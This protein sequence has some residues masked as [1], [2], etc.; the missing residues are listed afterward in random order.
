M[1][2]IH[3]RIIP[4]NPQAHLFQV[5]LTILEPAPEG[6]CLSLPAWIPGSYLIR[7][8]A[9]HVVQLRAESQGHPLPVEKLSKSLWQCAPSG[10]PVTINYEVYAWDSSVRAAHLDTFHGFF[11]GTSVFLRVEGQAHEPCT[12][13]LLPPEGETYRHWRVA[14]ALPRAGA[15]PYGFGDYQAGDYEEL[16]DHPVEMGEFSLVTFEACG[17]PHDIAITGRHRADME[18]LSRDLKI[19]CE[20]H[21][22]FFGEPAPMDRYVFLVTAVGEGYGGLEHRASCALLCNRSDLPQ[23]GETEVGEGYRNFL[24]LCSHEYFHTWNI[25]RIKPAAFVPYDLQQENYT[26]LLWAFEGITSYYDDLGLVRSGLISQESYLEL[27]GQTITR[28]LRGSGRLKQNLAESSF[29]AWT[30]FYQQDENA[31]NAIVSYYTKGALV[32]LALDL[33]LRW[34]TH[35][36]CSLDGVMRALWE[37]YGKTGVGVPEDGVERQVAEVSGLNITDFFEVA[38]RRAEDL[39]L[40]ALLAQVGICYALRVPESSDDKGGKP[41]KGGTPRARLGIRLVPNEKEA[42]ISQVFD[43]SAAQWAGLSAGDSLIA[44]DGIRVT[45]SNLEKVIS[46]YPGGARVIIH[47]FRRDELRE[48]EAALQLP[49]KDTCVLTIDEDASP[50]AVVAR[51]SWLKGS[52]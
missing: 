44:V 20:H 31:P 10:G 5:T 50:T 28:V 45:A 49:P 15:E 36:E 48:F 27:L 24:G 14:T 29:D 22:R 42:R 7:D 35:G 8:F 32:A 21:I 18:R 1:S 19:L 11:N 47:A 51:E 16:V 12:V 43:E 17:V 4:K 2:F 41:G 46:S 6:Q 37:S 52:A 33:T 39:P 3:Y 23:A 13:T 25:K 40:Q 26:R 38:L 30:K 34:E 9:K